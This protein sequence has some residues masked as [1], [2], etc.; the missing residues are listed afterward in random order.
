MTQKIKHTKPVIETAINGAALILIGF[1]A[2][3]I[4]LGGYNGYLM[5]TFGIALEYFKYWGRNKNLW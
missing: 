3:S 4:T 1:G 2:T 5:V